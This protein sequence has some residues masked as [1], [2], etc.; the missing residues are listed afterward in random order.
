MCGRF[1]QSS[2][3]AMI[4]E[5]VGAGVMDRHPAPRFNIAPSQ[6]AL[7]LRHR[8]GQ[9]RLD[10]LRWG[11]IPPWSKS[12]RGMI[13]AR[14][15][16][17]AE[18]PAF[19]RALMSRRCLVPADGFYEWKSIPAS[20][21]KQPYYIHAPEGEALAFAG[22]WERCSPDAG[23]CLETFTILTRQAEGP[24]A[25]IHSRM[26]LILS[27]EEFPV[28][29]GPGTFDGPALRRLAALPAPDGLLIH[30]VRTL[31]NNATQDGPALIEPLPPDDRQPGLFDC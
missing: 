18:K 15:E 10:Q 26:P 19:R 5:A 17:A 16:T 20:T 27:R 22:V 3:A 23:T 1:V 13:N 28:W 8:Q 7:I 9:P 4:A 6:Q 29:L 31:V 24:V 30:P 14:S 25:E 2:A 21:R 12:T 11:L